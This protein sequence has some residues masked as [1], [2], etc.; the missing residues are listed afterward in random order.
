MQQAPL[1]IAVVG[2]GF[3]GATHLKAW[4]NVPAARLYA[5][6]DA[7]LKRLSG[8]LSSVGGN[9]ATT[10]T[11]YDFSS[12]RTFT[13]LE[14]ALSEPE[15]DAVDICLPTDHH[16]ATTTAAL[17]AG[18]HVLCEKPL[19][20][21]SATA[22]SLC[23]EAEKAGR[24]LM[25]AHVLRFIPAYEELASHLREGSPVRSALFRRRCG[26]PG[27]S[28]W[29]TDPTR[30]GGAIL[31]MLI[32]DAD[33]CISLWGMP[34]AVRARGHRD[35]GRGIDVIHADLIYPNVG[36]VIITGGWHHPNTYPF[37]MEFTVVTDKATLEWVNPAT[38]FREHT[39]AGELRTTPLG[40]RDLF[41]AELAYFADCAAKNTQPVRCP[42]AQSTMAIALVEKILASRDQDGSLIA[43]W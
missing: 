1:N 38:D 30:S 39:V 5:V 13:T 28:P 22:E 18:K 27:W 9:L 8:D 16:A 26:A 33:F 40:D 14:Q 36:P 32:H 7:D 43:C 41:A 15:I 4:R 31:D 20:L 21:D 23:R 11:H 6:V 12:L 34:D 25:A 10:E 17:R 3:M 2:L 29:L 42:P 37:G 19:A 35:L 24:I